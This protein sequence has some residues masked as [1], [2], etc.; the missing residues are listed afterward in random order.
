MTRSDYIEKLE[1]LLCTVSE[2]EREEALQYYKDYFEDAS[3]TDDEI[4][5]SLGTPEEIV[6]SIKLGLHDDGK[7]GEFTETGFETNT[8][9]KNEL[10]SVTA[11]EVVNEIVEEKDD[12]NNKYS[13]GN[14]ELV[15][16][17]EPEVNKNDRT[18]LMIILFIICLPM[19]ISIISSVFGLAGGLI[20]TIFGLGFGLIGIII[21]LFAAAISLVI[22]GFVTISKIGL[23]G[24]LCLIGAGIIMVA[25]A[26]FTIW[27]TGLYIQLVK[28]LIPLIIRFAKWVWRAVFG[29]F[30][31]K[32]VNA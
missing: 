19:I 14:S 4:I 24:S 2:T 8:A 6:E 12:V 15:N 9:K 17:P 32:E 5:A 30:K 10:G 3:G 13:Y 27:I 21:G 11:L 1:K 26:I 7:N 29:I 22:V 20:G 31:K 23:Y 18:V 16:I 25:A 28:K